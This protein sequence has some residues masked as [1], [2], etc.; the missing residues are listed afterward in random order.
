MCQA[1]KG[2]LILIVD[3]K[4][5]YGLLNHRIT[6]LSGKKFLDEFRGQCGNFGCFNGTSG[7]SLFALVFIF[8][9]AQRSV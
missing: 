5:L 7:F 4:V 1:G 3:K 2:V 6:N 8:Q 9:V